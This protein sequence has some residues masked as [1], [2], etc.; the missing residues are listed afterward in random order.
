MI[1]YF[2]NHRRFRKDASGSATVEFVILFPIFMTLFVSCFELG[3][4]MLRQTMLDRSVDMTVRQIRL[5]A[6]DNVTHDV[7]RDMICAGSGVLRD[8]QSELKLEMEVVDPR[9]WANLDPDVDCVNHA[10]RTIP[11]REFRP[12]QENEMVI[13]RA[14]HLFEPFF[15]NFSLG[16][17]LGD[18]LPVETGN[19]Y[20]LVSIASFVVEPEDVGTP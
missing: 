9:A 5:G 19:S 8:C 11:P 10:D 20:R 14:C 15:D 13:I 12:G 2:C 18:L 3:T 7:V 1:R 16:P 17:A 6:V 4:V